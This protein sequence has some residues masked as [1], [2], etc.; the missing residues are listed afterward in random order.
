MGLF[1]RLFGNRKSKAVIPID[2]D[3][4][5]EDIKREIHDEIIKENDLLRNDLASELEKIYHALEIKRNKITDNKK[6]IE[7]MTKSVSELNKKFSDLALVGQ[8]SIEN[9][10]RLDNL[11]AE[12][13]TKEDLRTLKN[14]ILNK[15]PNTKNPETKIHQ[16][17]KTIETIVQSEPK[18][19]LAHTLERLP[20]S[21]RALVNILLQAESPI[22]YK[23][24]ASKMGLTYNTVKVY[25]RDIRE[26]GFPIE[27][28]LAQNKKLLN[29][30]NSVKAA[31]LYSE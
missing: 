31:L 7:D 5:K 23:Q 13:I 22:S 29:I 28:Y 19:P 24:I 11:P 16:L 6:R 8:L 4:M 15:H 25:I 30:P 9:K 10:E 1:D 3:Q 2:T 26:S 12:W 20:K 27:E 21:R 17:E 18:V 14:E